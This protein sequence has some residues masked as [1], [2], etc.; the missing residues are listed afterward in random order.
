MALF[1]AVGEYVEGEEDWSQ[2]VERLGHFFGANGVSDASKKRS[3]LLST[4]GPKAYQTLASLVAPETPGG[5]TYDE[6]I[7][8]MAEHLSP[9]PP[10]IVQRYR[11]HSRVRQQGESVSVYVTQLKELARKCEFG[12][13]LNDMLR[14]RLV[15]G[16]NDERVQ[17][18][19]LVEVNLTFD[20]ALK[21][22][23]GCEVAERCA[24]E[25]HSGRSQ[26]LAEHQNQ[27]VHAVTP[28]RP[29]NRSWNW[30]PEVLQVSA[31]GPRS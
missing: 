12:D 28:G 14:D 9:K 5:K 15:C 11:F 31:E 7:K 24:K 6:L 18:R 4:I 27:Q 19:L 23:Q 16:I 29:Q 1:G 26:E 30:N 17:K 20:S 2:Y 10:V 21:I 13:A 3:V 22:S 25:I 8:L